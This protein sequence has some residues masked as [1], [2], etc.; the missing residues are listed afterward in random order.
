M[1]P[2][3]AFALSGGAA[4]SI[5]FQS[6][7]GLAFGCQH[8]FEVVALHSSLL[9]FLTHKESRVPSSSSY[10]LITCLFVDISHA[11]HMIKDLRNRGEKNVLVKSLE[12][13]SIQMY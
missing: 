7:V 13:Q 4:L 11:M 8:G 12:L 9:L 10:F 3:N 2:L 6:V 1:T 5:W